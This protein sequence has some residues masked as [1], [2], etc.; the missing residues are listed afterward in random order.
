LLRDRQVLGDANRGVMAQIVPLRHRCP[1]DAI[2]GWRVQITHLSL[3]PLVSLHPPTV[4][5]SGAGGKPSSH[6]I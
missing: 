6:P 4:A 3:N 5:T 1:D 2:S